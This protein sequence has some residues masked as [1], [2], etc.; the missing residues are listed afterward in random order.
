[1]SKE[2]KD[3][4]LVKCKTVLRERIEQLASEIQGI[5]ESMLN[6]TKSSAGD[7]HET[8]RA[9]MQLENEKLCKM[10]SELE[11]QMATLDRI[12]FNHTPVRISSENIVITDQRIFFL[13]A[14]LGKIE[15]E[16]KEIFVISKESPI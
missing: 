14:A 8:A 9:R 15:S 2:F 10:M 11:E 6:E 1:M 7:K 12:R 3:L 16:G 4:L 13:A 5:N